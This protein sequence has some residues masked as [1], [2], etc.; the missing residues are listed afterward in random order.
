MRSPWLD[1]QRRVTQADVFSF[2]AL[3]SELRQRN[4]ESGL[5]LYSKAALEAKGRVQQIR[6]WLGWQWQMLHD[7]DEY[8]DEIRDPNVGL[9]THQC[10]ED[11]DDDW[12]SSDLPLLFGELSEGE[13]L[14]YDGEEDDGDDSADEFF[15]ALSD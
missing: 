1:R 10:T 15:D 2:Y 4:W 9:Y 8:R 5:F 14:A 12:T 6:R 7:D 11:S 3:L 13:A